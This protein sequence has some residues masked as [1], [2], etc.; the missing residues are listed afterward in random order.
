MAGSGY[1]FGM[2]DVQVHPVATVWHACTP[3]QHKKCRTGKATVTTTKP[4]EGFTLLYELHPL[5]Q[6]LEGTGE[7]G[8]FEVDW[9]TA[10]G[11]PHQVSAT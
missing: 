3:A 7:G 4:T 11:W 1:R 6:E 2:S 8:E 5:R 9:E 10:E